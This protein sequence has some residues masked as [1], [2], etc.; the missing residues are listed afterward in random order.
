MRSLEAWCFGTVAG[1][2]EDHADGL[3]FTYASAWLAEGHPPLS[4]SL[5][6]DGSAEVGAAAAFFGGLL[7]EGTPRAVLARQLGVSEQNDFS[8]LA[9]LGGDTAGAISLL[10]PGTHP[11]TGH[12]D[13]TWL[14]D[15][16]LAEEIDQLPSRPMHADED[17]EYRL[18]LA[19]AQDKLPVVVGADGRVG[20]TRGGTP[21][22]HI[23]K[24]PIRALQ[25][26]VANE[27]MCLDLGRRLIVDMVVA[28]PRRVE[29]REFLL[30]ARYDRAVGE[31]GETVRLHQE[32]VCQALG[33]PSARK[34]QAEGGPTLPDC[35]ALVRRAAAVPAREVMALLDQVV[36]SFLVGNHDAHGK[37]F[38][39]LHLPDATRLAPG[40]DVLSTFAYRGALRLSRKLAMSIGTEYR[41]DYV[42]ARHLT[43]MLE[44]AGL[45][46]AAARRRIGALAGAA[47]EH[48]REAH[49]QLARAGWDAPV[50]GRIEELVAQ[51]AGWLREITG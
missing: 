34:Y 4:Q 41:P 37:N 5:P 24:T 42:R 7:P 45:G 23:L 19:G 22:T 25:D 30:V 3:T 26:T 17:G 12:G 6:L 2:L 48:A 32:D 40:Y 35:F 15:A 49:D 33:I 51:R 13:V 8:L 43:T 44:A 29:G 39:L 46:Q 38:S 36:V 10:T 9:A 27:A 21:S 47:P 31:A 1:T 28:T 18:S 14:S 16:A 11:P 50:L 20:L